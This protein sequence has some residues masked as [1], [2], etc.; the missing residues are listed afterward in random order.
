MLIRIIR[1]I[2]Q[3]LVSQK[4]YPKYLRKRLG[5]V[6]GENCEIYK[7]VSFGSEPYLIR[8]GN[9]VRINNGVHFITHDGGCWVFR[10]GTKNYDGEL[11]NVDK[12]G[13]ITVGDNVHIGTNSFI[14]P[15]VKIGNNV[16]VGCCSVVTHDVP[17]N[18]VVVGIPARVIE[19]IDE[20]ASKNMSLFVRTKNMT[21]KDKKAFLLKYFNIKN[22]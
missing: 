1:K 13:M 4:N 18:T 3:K 14:M 11:S 5:M 17:D 9:H 20:Y 8:I 6:I 16:I 19:T 10:S 7:D 21:K 2:E 15:G 22:E 12:I